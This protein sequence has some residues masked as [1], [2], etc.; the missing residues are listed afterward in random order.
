MSTY[1]FRNRLPDRESFSYE[2]LHGDCVECFAEWCHHECHLTNDPKE[3]SD[4]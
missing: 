4:D 1:P 2:C 3:E